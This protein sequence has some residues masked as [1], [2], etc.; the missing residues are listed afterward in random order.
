[1]TIESK[2]PQEKISMQL[3]PAAATYIAERL[4]QNKD[5]CGLRLS[6]KQTGC[7]GFTYVAEMISVVSIEDLAVENEANLPIYMSKKSVVFL[8]NVMIDLQ[9]LPLRQRKLI[10]INPNETGRCGCGESFSIQ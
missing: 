9:E 7:S 8:N 6:T 5:T 1:M 3:T 2:T 10:Y 4:K